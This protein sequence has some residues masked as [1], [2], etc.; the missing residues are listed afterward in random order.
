MIEMLPVIPAVIIVSLA[1]IFWK[2]ILGRP[3]ISGYTRRQ[4]A[5][6]KKQILGILNES[7]E[8]VYPSEIA[9]RLHISYDICFEI[10]EELLKEG[11]VSYEE[12]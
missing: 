12:E 11:E 7:D 5:D 4:K 3:F 9:E 6:A 10:I 2:V 1:A 8:K